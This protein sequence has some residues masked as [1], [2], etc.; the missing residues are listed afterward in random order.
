MHETH[1]QPSAIYLNTLEQEKLAKLKPLPYFLYVS[2]LKPWAETKTQILGKQF[3]ITWAQL[4]E[5]L[6]SIPL[7]HHCVSQKLNKDN[8]RYAAALLEQAGLITL[9]STKQNLRVHLPLS[10]HK[11]TSFTTSAD[12]SHPGKKATFPRVPPIE[13]PI[14]NKNFI[15][16]LVVLFTLLFTRGIP[17]SPAHRIDFPS[18]FPRVNTFKNNKITENLPTLFPISAYIYLLFIYINIINIKNINNNAHFSKTEK[19][20]QRKHHT[21]S[22]Q[23]KNTSPQAVWFEQFWQAYPVKKAKQR[24]KQLFCKLVTSETLFHTLLEGLEKQKAERAALAQLQ[25]QGQRVFIPAWKYPATWLHQGCWEDEVGLLDEI[26][27]A[28]NTTHVSSG[29]NLNQNSKGSHSSYPA[30]MAKPYTFPI[31]T[32]FNQIDY[33]A[34][35]VTQH[36]QEPVSDTTQSNSS[37]EIKQ[38]PRATTGE[39]PHA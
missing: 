19:S 16:N 39:I 32:D 20:R 23:Q 31:N 27:D 14:E 5:K 13:F 30:N 37:Y 34:H 2:A 11:Q 8:L 25:A 12:F 21:P 26:A 28:A 6:H 33:H 36:Q 1:P 22:A 17:I 18:L 9:L 10:E 38:P 24:V 3:P 29:I 4:A 15:N 7:I 35:E